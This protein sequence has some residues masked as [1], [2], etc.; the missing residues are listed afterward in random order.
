MPRLMERGAQL[1]TAGGVLA[2]KASIVADARFAADYLD[3]VLV[4]GDDGLLMRIGAETGFTVED[5]TGLG[6]LFDSQAPDGAAVPRLWSLSKRGEARAAAWRGR[7]E[8][9]VRRII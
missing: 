4:S 6:T 7:E 5:G 3:F 9:F 8:W 1:L 2:F